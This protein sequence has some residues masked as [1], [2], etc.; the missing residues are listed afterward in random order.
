[1][2]RSLHEPVEAADARQPRSMSSMLGWVFMLAVL[3]GIGALWLFG[4]FTPAAGAAGG[5]GGA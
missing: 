1:M 2:M 3:V 4:S 5:C